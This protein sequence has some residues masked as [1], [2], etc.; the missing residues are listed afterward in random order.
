MA[1]QAEQ[2]AAANA[3]NNLVENIADFD[4]AFAATD[5]HRDDRG[6]E[7]IYIFTDSSSIKRTA[8]SIEVGQFAEMLI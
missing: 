6:A 4:G 3:T 7:I 2:F 8:N 1:T 5:G